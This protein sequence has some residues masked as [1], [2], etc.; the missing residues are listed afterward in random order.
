MLY[1]IPGNILTNQ[2]NVSYQVYLCGIKYS[3]L[4]QSEPKTASLR[5]I[6]Q[7]CHL[8]Y[9]INAKGNYSKLN[10]NEK[11]KTAL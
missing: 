7:K 1:Y 11:I 2:F 8:R 5:T 4:D 3:R 10:L 9:N 6:Q